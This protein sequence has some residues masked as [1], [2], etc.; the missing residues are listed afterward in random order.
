MADVKKVLTKR[1]LVRRELLPPL[2]DGMTVSTGYLCIDPAVRLRV[3][4]RR[5]KIQIW[6]PGD[7]T[8]FF[9]YEVP[10]SEAESMMDLCLERTSRT[11]WKLEHAGRTWRVHEYMGRHSGVVTAVLELGSRDGYEEPPWAG[12][13]VTGDSRYT[14]EGLARLQIPPPAS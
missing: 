9:E 13:N 14:D 12:K 11:T 4:E 6:N 2:K 10:I 1:Y 3:N 8:K 5:A 7:P